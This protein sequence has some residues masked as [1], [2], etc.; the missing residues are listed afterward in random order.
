MPSERPAIPERLVVLGPIEPLLA[1]LAFVGLVSALGPWW[2]VY[3]FNPDEGIGLMK[4][5]LLAGG[6]RLYGEIWSD[7]PPGLTLAL[8]LLHRL[9][10]FDVASAR[11]VVL[12]L[13]ALLVYS[14]FRIVGRSE[15]RAAA[16]LAVLV[17]ISSSLFQTYAVTV[18]IGLP[19]IAL[20][21]AS[22]DHALLAVSR[23]ERW[24]LAVAGGLFALSL[25]TKLFTLTLVP[26]LLAALVLPAG[27]SR[28]AV[29]GG[30]WIGRVA[31]VSLAAVAMWLL[32]Y[33][34]VGGS[35]WSQIVDPHL[36]AR[37][38]YSQDGGIWKL[39]SLF[40]YGAAVVV[41]VGIASCAGVRSWRSP[42]RR[43]L[44]LWLIAAVVAL[45]GHRPLWTHH[46]LLLVVP[47]AWAAGL[48]VSRERLPVSL[49]AGI[50][51]ELPGPRRDERSKLARLA[52][53]FDVLGSVRAP[54]LVAL[55]LAA[56]LHSSLTA[57]RMF[58]SEPSSAD[59]STLRTL[60]HLSAVTKW[61]V[62]D[63]PIDAY[64]AALLVP[65]SLAVF[66]EKR[67]RN[68]GLSRDTLVA[69]IATHRPALVSWRRFE[70]SA[71]IVEYL[72]SEYQRVATDGVGQLF[73]AR[74]TA[75]LAALLLT[76]RD[77]IEMSPGDSFAANY[78]L[79]TGRRFGEDPFE[80]LLSDSQIVVS[81]PG[82]AQE[83]GACF[84]EAFEVTGVQA[85]REAA[86]S[87]ARS[88]ARAQGCLGGWG[89]VATS[90]PVCDD[91]RAPGDNSRFAEV[92]L[93]DGTTQSAVGFLMELE[94]VL[95]RAGSSSP[96]WL[97]TAISRGLDAVLL[98]QYEEGGWPQRFSGE[99]GS[100]YADYAT[101][102]DGATTESIKLLLRA[103]AATDASRFLDA[104][105]RGG[106]FLLR[107]QGRPP[108]AAWAQQYDLALRP[109]PARAFEPAAYASLETAYAIDALL[110]LYLATAE[111]R[112]RE[113]LA[114]ASRW[115]QQAQI[116]P[117]QWARL[118]QIGTN[119]PI[120]GDR[121]GEVRYA[122]AEISEERRTRYRWE[123]GFETFP[124]IELALR[125]LQTFERG[126]SQAVREW[127][128][129]ESEGDLLA[130]HVTARVR[131]APAPGNDLV[132]AWLRSGP[133]QVDGIV[134][135]RRFAESCATLL[136]HERRRSGDARSAALSEAG[137]GLLAN[138]RRGAGR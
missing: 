119:R 66:S 138:V 9:H 60:R 90:H 107:V 10:G 79:S 103:Y 108:Q 118:Y 78:E 73:V 53:R 126:G 34:L 136:A 76:A 123:G 94:A 81:P 125:R 82:S 109:A 68:G 133:A 56:A 28:A 113:P 37:Q 72:G 29:G 106:E 124:E 98:A 93:D 63:R 43:A 1:A 96:E 92:R 15:G 3:E 57:A 99:H 27:R 17:L 14:L 112:F 80:Q 11:G 62:T 7:Q 40:W 54:Y 128:A 44:L 2:A 39:A 122:L 115:L 69:A 26:A 97:R 100:A 114:S 85:M 83:I 117:G 135:A 16:W 33:W 88:L 45:L 59:Q 111:V 75:P 23:G 134:S 137:G 89:A 19:A 127:D 71:E 13:A 31:A 65:P 87:V 21:T 131:A 121:D 50:V 120:Y 5:A 25:Q 47:L 70:P 32:V 36:R 48:A 20:G 52:N 64:R 55:V 4:A 86:L 6:H 95:Q 46:A 61:M 104:A 35:P 38:S 51:R 84:L 129:A 30:G 105:M 18:A 58:R 24:R 77:L 101:L 8:A 91:T 67:V 22:L 110:D 41:P 74:R 116:A 130:R 49:A 102:N 12:V 132:T 42:E